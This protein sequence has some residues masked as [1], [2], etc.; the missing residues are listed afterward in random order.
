[1][2]IT[3]NYLRMQL[4]Y[5][6]FVLN[7]PESMRKGKIAYTNHSRRE[8][9]NLSNYNSVSEMF[10]NL[11]MSSFDEILQKFVFDF[12]SRIINSGISFVNGIVK[13]SLSLLSKH[14]EMVMWYSQHILL[15]IAIVVWGDER[16]LNVMLTDLDCDDM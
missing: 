8:D 10:V 14:M 13:Y 15:V 9:I 4:N 2:L 12:K 5:F 16:H 7:Q 11:N 1:M 6:L 3:I